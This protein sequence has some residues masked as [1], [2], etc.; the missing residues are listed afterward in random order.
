[1]Q[2]ELFRFSNVRRAARVAASKTSS[3]PSPVK[4]EH[5]RYFLA[6]SDVEVSLPSLAVTK[7]SDFFRISSIA[8]GSSRRSFFKPTMMIG[9]PGHRS[10]A[11]SAH[12]IEV[13]SR[14]TDGTRAIGTTD[15]MLYILQRIRGV[16]GEADQ[17]DV[18]FG[19][20]QRAQTL[21]VLLSR[22][23]PQGQL[24]RPSIHP[25]I[26]YIVLE[27]GGDLGRGGQRPTRQTRMTSG[28]DEIR[29]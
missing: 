16:D 13:I 17:D 8:M 10:F 3:T 12:C 28:T 14:R 24:D 15:L 19:I 4:D 26:C 5:S 23:I 29:T 9:T 2:H 6:P 21:V 7:R 20:G 11:S 27:N 1:M 18:R 25:T 22:G